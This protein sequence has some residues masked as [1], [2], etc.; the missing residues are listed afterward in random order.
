MLPPWGGIC[1][2]KLPV[3]VW[4]FFFLARIALSNFDTSTMHFLNNLLDLNWRH[5]VTNEPP[6]SDVTDTVFRHSALL[7]PISL[8][9]AIK[10]ICKSEKLI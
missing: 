10:V 6:D 5:Y 3:E 4:D 9:E 8:H 7:K 1:L 2:G